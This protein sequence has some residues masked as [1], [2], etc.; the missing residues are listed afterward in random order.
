MYQKDDPFLLFTKAN[1]QGSLAWF[2]IL[3]GR[4][5]EAGQAA[6][7][8][9]ELAP[10]E[11][12]IYSNL[13]ASYLLQGKFEEAKKIY[14]QYADAPADPLH[15]RTMRTIFLADIDQFE[16]K[17]ITHKDFKKVRGLLQK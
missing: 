3:S 4:Y 8:G 15:I 1:H 7:K 16:Q 10:N 13:A 6:Q 17:G 9:L 2:S 12:W 14:T 11:T 5:E